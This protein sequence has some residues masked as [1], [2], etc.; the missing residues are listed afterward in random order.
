MTRH[1]R[2]SFRPKRGYAARH[3]TDAL[4]AAQDATRC[5]AIRRAARHIVPELR[6]AKFSYFEFRHKSTSREHSEQA[7]DAEKNTLSSRRRGAIR[8]ALTS[9]R[10]RFFV[11]LT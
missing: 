7:R 2:W 6:A 4:D 11:C 9:R 5:D 8:E 10:M 3:G 1:Y